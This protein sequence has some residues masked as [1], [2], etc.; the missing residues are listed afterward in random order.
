MSERSENSGPKDPPA[1]RTGEARS[2]SR[3]TLSLPIWLSSES[4]NE[5]DALTRDIS[6][7]GV[8]FY[9]H[10]TLTLGADLQ[11]VTRIPIK[12]VAFQQMRVRYGGR[13]VRIERV[14]EGILGIAVK[15]DRHE[16][17]A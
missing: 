13:V 12:S 10:S 1:Q 11:F 4:T 14:H 6:A 15:I 16:F 7:D 9:T 17:L 8:F 5:P 3:F 2:L